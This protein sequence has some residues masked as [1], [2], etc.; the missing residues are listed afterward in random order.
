M[1]NI[2]LI[3][4]MGCG[5]TSVGKRL[6]QT[7]GCEFLDTDEWIEHKQKRSISE[8]FAT[9][10]EAAFREMETECLKSLLKR[11]GDG[12]VLSVGGG[13]PIREVNRNLLKELGDV[14]LLQ[15]S[16]EVVYK[17]LRNDKTR[18]LLHNKNP[19][20]RI[21]DLMSARKS[22]YED[23]AMHIVD[24]NERDFEQIAAD[25]LSVCR[26]ERPQQK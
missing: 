26:K 1:K 21:L 6:S 2:I 25:I 19:L 20:G 4:F 13:L 16:P 7:L 15:V 3:G 24:V 11:G 5:K 8:I 12:F 17:R 23:A 14:V 22:Y 10:G 9:D 18:P